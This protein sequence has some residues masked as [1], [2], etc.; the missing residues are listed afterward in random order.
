MNGRRLKNEETKLDLVYHSNS[1][2]AALNRKCL[3]DARVTEIAGFVFDYRR[4]RELVSRA[5]EFDHTIT[6][7]TMLE[8]CNPLFSLH[9]Q[10][11]TLLAR[12]V[13]CL[14]KATITHQVRRN[15]H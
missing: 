10:T 5:F 8:A 4:E 12:S 11:L 14:L 13:A 15:I 1:S 9:L 7:I 3:S 6:N 2:F